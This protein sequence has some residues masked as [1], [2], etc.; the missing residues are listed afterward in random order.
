[1]A[2]Q[3]YP[4]L[5][6]VREPNPRTSETTDFCRAELEKASRFEK[7][8][9]WKQALDIYIN[10]VG[11]AQKNPG[12]ISEERTK[13]ILFRAEHIK[14]KIEPTKLLLNV[15]AGV[16]FIEDGVRSNIALAFLQKEKSGFVL[17]NTSNLKEIYLKNCRILKRNN[18]YAI[19][20]AFT[21]KIYTLEFDDSFMEAGYM[22]NIESVLSQCAFEFKNDN[23]T[24]Q[25]PVSVT[26]I[27]E[28]PTAPMEVTDDQVLPSAPQ[29]GTVPIK[30]K[31]QSDKIASG[32][33][34]GAGLLGTGITKLTAK[35]DQAIKDYSANYVATTKPNE[36]PTEVSQT[37][38]DALQAGRTGMH[39]TS[40]GVGWV[41]GKVG[42]GVKYA[43]GKVAD[44]VDEKYMKDKSGMTNPNKE[45]N[46]DRFVK[47]GGA[48]LAAFGQVWNSL[49]ENLTDV[50][51]T[52]RVEGVKMVDKK[53]GEEAAS[54]TD[55]AA[56][57]VIDGTKTY[58]Y[59]DSI[60]MKAIAKNTAKE[61]GKIV[62]KDQKAKRDNKI[63]NQQQIENSHTDQK[64]IT[65]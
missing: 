26:S 15:P 13:Q 57:I 28:T 31:T 65:K 60:G 29:A 17:I 58:F 39:Y 10:L 35:T 4:S 7:D 47:I 16:N 48:S 12:F 3:L 44:H 14:I 24:A 63:I 11:Y 37:T 21:N 20:D 56:R 59:I 6:S 22:E 27:M 33:L 55:Y 54:A 34:K 40:K 38:K 50:S 9:L 23:Q 52:G 42:Q 43:A 51:R 19:H 53:Y 2:E 36:K 49:E 41:A 64:A 30:T 62:I 45:T 1:M 25:R 61:A 32:I 5:D 8:G 18:N 46:M